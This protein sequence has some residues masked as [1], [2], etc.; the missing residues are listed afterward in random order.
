MIPDECV[1]DAAGL[2]TFLVAVVGD[3]EIGEH[4]HV[5][6]REGLHMKNKGFTLIE[7]MV[8]MVI[9]G[10]VLAVVLPSL[11]KHRAK[12]QSAPVVQMDSTPITPAPQLT[13]ECVNGFAFVRG[14]GTVIQKMGSDGL[15]ARCQ[16]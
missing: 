15:P 8:V 2:L 12:Q 5:R 3:C 4:G 11:N 7:V 16:E 1:E 9:I 6:F 14:E 10:I 13:E